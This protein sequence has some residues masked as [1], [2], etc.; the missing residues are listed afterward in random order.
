MYGL[1][2]RLPPI[3]DAELDLEAGS[4]LVID[5]DPLTLRLVRQAVSGSHHVVVAR[6][7]EEAM[8]LMEEACPDAVVLDSGLDDAEVALITVGMAACE[9]MDAIPTVMID[10]DQPINA[11]AIRARIDAALRVTRRVYLGGGLRHRAGI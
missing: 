1:T 4:V 9:T 2:H 3:A 5:R 6:D 7:A 11:E 8:S 10:L